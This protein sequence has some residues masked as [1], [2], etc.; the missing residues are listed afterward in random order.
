MT[1]P[2]LVCELASSVTGPI[3][4][5][6][7]DPDRDAAMLREWFDRP[8][9]RFWGMSGKSVEAVRQKYSELQATPGMR[10]L[11][12]VRASDLVPLF[13]LETCDPA[14]D[15]IARHVRLQA[16]DLGFHFMN[17]PCPS[18][19]RGHTQAVMQMVIGHLLSAPDVARLIVEPDIRNARMLGRLVEA[20]FEREAVVHLSS[21]T[22]WVMALTRARHA[23]LV[24]SGRW[25][26][27]QQ[28]V[29]GGALRWHLLVGR[30]GRKLGL[31]PRAR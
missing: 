24:Q 4:L 8:E 20:G 2:A 19:V 9:A 10:V 1:G 15:A 16:G 18:H 13:L 7:V 11:L 30:V 25:P 31:L 17:A 28:P 27:R 5:R 21:K 3:L 26:A 14:Q 22:A 23:V 6:Q 12:G 29:A